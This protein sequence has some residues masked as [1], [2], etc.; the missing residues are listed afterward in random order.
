MKV[1]FEGTYYYGMMNIGYRATIIEDGKRVIELNIF[2]FSADI[3]NKEITVYFISRLR[4]EKKF[5]SK[6]ELIEQIK[7]DKEHSIKILYK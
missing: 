1:A 4:E 3:Y 2:D 7:I 5:N 6:E